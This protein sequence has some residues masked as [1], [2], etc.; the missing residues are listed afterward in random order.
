MMFYKNLL[1]MVLVVGLM[2]ACNGNREQEKARESIDKLETQAFSDTV[3]M[4]DSALGM[5][6][7]QAYTDYANAY[8][9]DTLSA[10]YLFKGAEIAMNMKMAGLAI[11]TYKRILSSYPTFSKSDYCLFLQ[12]F[13]LE[14]QLQQ[15]D[16]AKVVYEEFVTLYPDHPMA[17]DARMSIQNMGVPLEDLIR[18]WESQNTK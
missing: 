15:F 8:P 10:E 9:D 14:N 5:E 13:I 2:T 7:I 6:M 12:A 3:T 1:A 11:D 18:Q 17:D 4:I 16:Q